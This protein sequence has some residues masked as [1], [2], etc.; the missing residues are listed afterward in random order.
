V[1]T[2]I[3]NDVRAF[4]EIMRIL[5]V[6]GVF[7]FTVSYSAAQEKTEL[8]S[9]DTHKSDLRIYGSDI[10][11]RFGKKGKYQ[12]LAVEGFDLIDFAPHTAFIAT[13]SL[14]RAGE[15][16]EILKTTGAFSVSQL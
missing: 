10:G 11:E 5:S 3:E 16:A 6:D 1:L 9:S 4:E 14:E 13:H 8:T 2:S 15:I 12:I 7:V